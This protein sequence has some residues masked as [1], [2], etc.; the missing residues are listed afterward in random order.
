MKNILLYIISTVLIIFLLFMAGTTA[1]GQT[2][3]SGLW[4]TAYYSIDYLFWGTAPPGSPTDFK[5]WDI[6]WRS[7]NYCI[8]FTASPRP[9]TYPYFGPVALPADSAYLEHATHSNGT[10][11]TPHALDSFVVIAKRNGTV[12]LLC[13]GGVWGQGATDMN[14]IARDSVKMETYAQS[15]CAYANRKGFGGIDID[16]EF[17]HTFGSDG[18][19][20]FSRM[21]KI[22]RRILDTWPTRGVLSAAVG[23]SPWA[24]SY[25]IAVM[26]TTLDQI[27]IMAYDMDGGNLAWFNSPIHSDR[28]N[29]PNCTPAVGLQSWDSYTIRNWKTAGADVKKLCQLIPFYG[30]IN[31]GATNIGSSRTGRDYR[32]Y[33]QWRDV[34][35]AN[36][37]GYHYND[38]AQTPYVIYSGG[39]IS[40]ENPQSI[41]AKANRVIAEG[42][43]GIGIYNL[44]N[45]VNMWG[46]PTD[47][48]QPLMTAFNSVVGPKGQVVPPTEIPGV[49]VIN[50]PVNNSTNIPIVTT[51]VWNTSSNATTYGIQVSLNVGFTTFVYNQNG[52]Y[53]TNFAATFS[54]NTTY[55]WRVNA[56]NTVGTSAWANTFNFKTVNDTVVVPPID[57][58]KISSIN[59]MNTDNGTAMITGFTGGTINLAT[60]ASKNFSF[61]AI[62]NKAV[63]SIQ[64]NRD[65]GAYIKTESNAPYSSC[66]D[67]FDGGGSSY[68]ACAWPLGNH[69]LLMTPYSGAGA[70]GIAGVSF[71]LSFRLI[72]S[73]SVIPV[74]PSAP[75][76]VTPG[77]ALKDRDTSIVF[78]W[79]TV[80]NASNYNLQTA[81]M[82]DF[83][84]FVSQITVSNTTYQMNN[85]AYNTTYY[86]RVNATNAAGTGAWSDVWYF[87]TKSKDTC[88]GQL[89]ST[90]IEEGN[91]TPIFTNVCGFSQKVVANNPVSIV[92][93]NIDGVL[94]QQDTIAVPATEFTYEW[95][96]LPGTLTDGWHT[97][98][99]GAKDPCVTALSAPYPMYLAVSQ[100]VP[101]TASKTVV[102]ASIYADSVMSGWLCQLPPAATLKA[103]KS[104]QGKYSMNA[105]LSKTD[106]FV[107]TKATE[108]FANYAHLEFRLYTDSSNTGIQVNFNNMRVDVVDIPKTYWTYVQIPI[109]TYV[110]TTGIGINITIRPTN[111]APRNI[112][113]D[114]LRL[115]K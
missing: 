105:K 59:V 93:L 71:N 30:V 85:L 111:T 48:F 42:I 115:T 61:V 27:N 12:P 84:E 113:I 33:D 70:T 36:P 4:T 15:S 23:Q 25:D 46:K 51:L 112:W 18:V 37:A 75:I 34:I 108:N 66:G 76:L 87:T 109:P 57:T 103:T 14:T 107:F 26:N 72:D 64:F 53:S 88:S 10:T 100:V 91:T 45:G 92:F 101:Y 68:Y 96:V 106:N 114:N 98:I 97:F 19:K 73:T 77:I 69:T 20:Y 54:K 86:W 35:A 9:A 24:S 21:L 39:V 32:N 3:Q 17:P 67:N 43:K 102:G 94:Y 65:N 50:T 41:A 8:Y 82:P 5:P 60:L 55:Y 79:G 7:L 62:P 52:I 63:G 78:G 16:W 38:S 56:T 110:K 1:F 44:G 47:D 58:L 83:S 80:T 6:D 49:P 104:Y 95:D 31:M 2:T 28:T 99:V 40:A 90:F 13:V 74:P 22:Y 11:Y 89:I 29:F 81:N